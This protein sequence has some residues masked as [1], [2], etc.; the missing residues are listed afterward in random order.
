VSYYTAGRPVDGALLARDGSGESAPTDAT[1]AFDLSTATSGG[2]MLVP[3][4]NDIPEGAVS[5]LDAAYVLQSMVKLRTLDAMQ[6]L[7]CD[8]TGNGSLSS[9]DAARILQYVVKMHSLPLADTCGSHWLFVPAIAESAQAH[10]LAPQVSTGTCRP[11]AIVYDAAADIVDGQDFRALVIGDCTGNWAPAAGGGA[12]RRARGRTAVRLSRIRMLAASDAEVTVS[13][14]SRE[15]FVALTLELA[16][17]PSALRPKR[18]RPTGAARNAVV[19]FNDDGQGA[20]RV[21]LASGEP[22]R[23]SGSQIVIDWDR[24][25]PNPPRDAVRLIAAAVDE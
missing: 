3:S 16:Y 5:S 17:D 11:G 10:P 24:V 2:W 25:G 7:A 15:P 6:K 18:A 14:R 21:A 4:K 20:L 1:G 12:A 8:V 19:T 23:A 9:L 13:V 22:L